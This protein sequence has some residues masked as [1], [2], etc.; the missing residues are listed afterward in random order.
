LVDGKS[1]T[2]F[3]PIEF[4]HGSIALSRD[5]RELL[6]EIR[7]SLRLHPDAVVVIETRDETGAADAAR[8]RVRVIQDYLRTGMSDTP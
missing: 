3:Q 6:D 8:Q 5:A 7:S 4:E 2:T 1:R